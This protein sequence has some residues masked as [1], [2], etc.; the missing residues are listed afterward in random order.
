MN[1][2]E[3]S[4]TAGVV[5]LMGSLRPS[6]MERMLVSAATYWP[7]RY[8]GATVV[9]QG[10]SHPFASALT[11]AGYEVR[12]IRPLTTLRGAW[13][14]WRTARHNRDAVWHIHVEREYA[15]AALVLRLAGA[16]RIVRTIHNTFAREGIKG[17]ARQLANEIADRLVSRVVAVSDDVAAHERGYGREVVTVLNWVDDRFFDSSRPPRPAGHI[18][19][20]F[21]MV[22][23]CSRIKDH[24]LAIA[25][26]PSG[27]DLIHLG[28]ESQ[29]Q[30]SEYQLLRQL[31]E[32]GELAFRGVA[33]PVPYLV[34]ADVF[35]MPSRHEGMTVAL[36][37]ALVIGCHVVAAD[38]PG[39]R[40][41]RDF[42]G[43][44]LISRDPAAWFAALRHP[45]SAQSGR[46]ST[47]VLRASRG[48]REYSQIYD[49]VSGICT[50]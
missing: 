30:E 37:E 13:K 1:M 48:V 16:D 44:T 20:T 46:L 25:A 10:P 17:H 35:I 29:I 39:V 2:G 22:G 7:T 28:D 49:D 5:H 6:G 41:A 40:W 8:Q 19:N 24:A 36:A 32:R 4:V 27:C 11:D 31:E 9:G 42:P 26:L 14:L 45:L 3:N 34:D 23:N 38:V 50:S 18:P 15:I 47:A 12:A 43:V 33:D 21:V